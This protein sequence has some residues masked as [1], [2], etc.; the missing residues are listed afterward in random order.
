MS[1]VEVDKTLASSNYVTGYTPSRDDAALLQ[2]LFGGNTATLAWAAKIA[3][4]YRVE[5]EEIL[6]AGD[7]KKK[8]DDKVA[9]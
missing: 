5:R 8:S 6:T 9:K 7:A 2:E 1:L 3:T 4:Y